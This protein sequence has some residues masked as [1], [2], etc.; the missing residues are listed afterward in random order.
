MTRLVLTLAALSLCAPALAADKDDEI[1]LLSEDAPELADPSDIGGFEAPEGDVVEDIEPISGDEPPGEFLGDIAE[2]P[3][4]DFMPDFTE[5]ARK[6]ASRPAT[7]GPGPISLDV[8]GKE[9]LADNYPVS[10]VSVDRDAVVVE[11]PVLVGRSRVGFEKDFTI[12]GQVF[13]GDTQV[14]TVTA[15]ITEKSLAD[16]GPSFV[17]LKVLAPVVEPEGQVTVKVQ[18]DGEELFAR[19]TP[20]AL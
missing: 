15:T 17:F 14:G 13:V 12:T 2:D 3:E 19:S 18:K 5:P 7:Q 8:A 6:E 1:D 20:Y 10:V 9:P 4:G 16:F 11:L